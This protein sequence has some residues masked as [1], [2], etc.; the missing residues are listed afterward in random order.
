MV[1]TP[2]LMVL[3]EVFDNSD[4]FENTNDDFEIS[5]TKCH[6]VEYKS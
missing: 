6:R 1:N 4:V 2:H 3:Q 5:P